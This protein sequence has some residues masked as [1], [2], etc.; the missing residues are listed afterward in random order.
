MHISLRHGEVLTESNGGKCVRGDIA[1]A[2]TRVISRIR[3][4][5]SGTGDVAVAC[6]RYGGGNSSQES[7]HGGQGEEPVSATSCAW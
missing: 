6:C 5:V 4:W 2:I 7:K 1:Q 3:E